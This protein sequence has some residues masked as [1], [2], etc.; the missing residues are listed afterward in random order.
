MGARYFMHM[1]LQH[2]NANTP[3]ARASYRVALGEEGFKFVFY[4]LGI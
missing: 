2:S 1:K 4:S 3:A